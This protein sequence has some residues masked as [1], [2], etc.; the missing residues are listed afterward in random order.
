MGVGIAILGFFGDVVEG[1]EHQ[2]GVLE[3]FGGD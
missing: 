2:Q 3:L 1:V